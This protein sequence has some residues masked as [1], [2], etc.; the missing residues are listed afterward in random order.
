VSVEDWAEIEVPGMYAVAK[1]GEDPESWQ[2]VT[3]W[4]DTLELLNFHEEQLRMARDELAE[5]WPPERS[6]AATAFITYVDRLLDQLNVAQNDAAANHRALALLL[7]SLNHAKADMAALNAQFAEHEAKEQ[8]RSAGPVDY[9]KYGRDAGWREELNKRG[10]RR[11]GQADQEVFE[12][13]NQM[14]RPAVPAD[15]EASPSDNRLHQNGSSDS[16]S[17]ANGVL[18]L[19][20]A[21]VPSPSEVDTQLQQQSFEP[22]RWSDYSAALA[23][24]SNGT[25]L[26]P[27]S[28]PGQLPTGGA[29]R[30]GDPG[31]V[32]GLIPPGT[33]F[34]RTNAPGG[35]FNPSRGLPPQTATPLGR[36][37]G[38]GPGTAP[39]RRVNPVGGVIGG[40]HSPSTP[41]P[42]GAS[43]RGGTPSHPA[44]GASRASGPSG[45]GAAAR[46]RQRREAERPGDPEAYRIWPVA[47]GGPP[48]IES[49]PEPYHDPGPGVIGID[50]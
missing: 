44:T 16:N 18:S 4:W 8:S 48:V 22:E 17:G 9:T 1:V 36:S 35:T 46:G 41:S 39:G 33:G 19:R 11:M 14:V 31:T 50:R 42:H 24:G 12:A 23:A 34:P 45:L 21:M 25:A 40:N 15:R 27:S 32:H 6:P 26:A 29:P 30:P 5:M 20:Q 49:Q 28:G 2:Q 3:A 43:A 38:G 37:S 13:S 47:E 10:R 7:L